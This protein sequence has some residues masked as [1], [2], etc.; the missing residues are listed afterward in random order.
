MSVVIDVA[1]QVIRDKFVAE[2]Q[3]AKARLDFEI[4]AITELLAKQREIFRKL[5]PAR[6]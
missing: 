6:K 5:R 2:I 4:K 1:K 3:T